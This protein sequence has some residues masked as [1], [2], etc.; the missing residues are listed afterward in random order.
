M[1]RSK[2]LAELFKKGH[3]LQL[4]GTPTTLA[5]EVWRMM[6]GERGAPEFGPKAD[7]WSLACVLHTLCTGQCMPMKSIKPRECL[8]VIDR[9][10]P[11]LFKQLSVCSP[12]LQ[13]LVK[14]ML[15]KNPHLRPSAKVTALNYILNV[16]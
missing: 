16:K 4:G 14:K 13:D 6:Q 9:F 8:Q 3:A 1:C 5:P 7:I 12:A 2:G 10:L 11:T 15:N